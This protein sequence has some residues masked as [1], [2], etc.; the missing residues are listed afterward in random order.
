[1]ERCLPA[2]R[3]SITAATATA[4]IAA[5]RPWARRQLRDHDH[6]RQHGSAGGH[7]ELCSDGEPGAVINLPNAATFTVEQTSNFLI[8]TIPGTPSTTSL[9]LSGTLPK[10]FTFVDNGN[11]TAT[12]SGTPTA[13]TTG[14]YGLTI[15]ASNGATTTQSFTLTVN[16][17]SFFLGVPTA[18]MQLGVN[19]TVT[20]F[21]NGF[22][23]AVIAQSGSLPPG[24]TFTDRGD[25]TAVLT[26]APTATGT[27]LL[28]LTA[29]NGVLPAAT[30]QFTLNV[31]QAPT[32]SST[33][34]TTF[35][36]GQFGTFKVTTT[37]GTPIQATLSAPLPPNEKL[38]PGISFVDNGNGTATLSGTPTPSS[39]GTYTF[40]ITADNG[41]SSTQTFTLTISQPATFTAARATFA[42]GQA[43]SFTVSTAGFPRRG[44]CRNGLLAGRPHVRR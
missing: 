41:V 20:I 17:S 28:T 29:T 31:D 42:L 44:A 43:N 33:G 36:A 21:T 37:P 14:G 39:G 2:C 6:G 11:G 12:I 25:G 13:G 23:I 24:V 10:G 7:S 9:S 22:P 26:G 35:T 3:S 15:T 16:Q 19:Q 40:T 4:T 32:I 30:E 34:S 1:M 38:P 18:T 8:T 5:R 27:Y